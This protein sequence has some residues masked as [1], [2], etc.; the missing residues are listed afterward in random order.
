M[1][2]L[3]LE[4]SKVLFREEPKLLVCDLEAS[5]RAA[6]GVADLLGCIMA[7]VLKKSGDQAYHE[8]MKAVMM[9]ANAS[10]LATANKADNIAPN[11]TSQ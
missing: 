8:A 4:L 11:T 7:T 9:R 10:A 3:G 2:S 6:V 1:S 5:A